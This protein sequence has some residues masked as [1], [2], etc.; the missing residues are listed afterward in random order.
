MNIVIIDSGI[1]PQHSH[2]GGAVDGLSM[3]MDVNGQIVDTSDFSD[4]IGHGTAIAGIV[5]KRVPNAPIFAIKIFHEAL[6]AP[7]SL[8]IAALKRAIERK[9][10]LIHLSLGTVLQE[11]REPLGQLCRSAN[12]NNSI[13]VAAARTPDDVV[14][15]S[16]FESVIGVCQ[17]K[18][19]DATTIARYTDNP[20][21]FGA[22]GYPRD[23][24][25]LPRELNFH[26]SSFAAAHVTS[27]VA[28]ILEENPT[29]NTDEVKLR[30]TEST[31]TFHEST[32]CRF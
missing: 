29:F 16:V 7:L 12:N 18:N 22:C 19:C 15:P 28:R 23:I 1:N 25:G 5:R 2:V 17:D 8:L 20:I 26:G 6:S 27:R 10:N 13:I 9:P 30:L 4:S 14:Y 11:S 3:K 31:D 21:E 32:R 24:Q